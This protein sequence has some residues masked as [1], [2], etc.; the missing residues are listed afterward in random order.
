MDMSVNN[1]FIPWPAVSGLNGAG[2]PVHV[3]PRDL[4]MKE[5]ACAERSEAQASNNCANLL[6]SNKK[7]RFFLTGGIRDLFVF[8]SDR[9]IQKRVIAVF[10]L[11]NFFEGENNKTKKKNI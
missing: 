10:F 1:S 11:F 2:R 3:S 4:S 7:S 8:I 5:P 9:E 6:T